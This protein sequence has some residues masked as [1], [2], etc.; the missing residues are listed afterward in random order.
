MAPLYL[1]VMEAFYAKDFA[2][3]DEL[4]F[5]AIRIVE[6]LLQ[7]GGSIKAGKSF[8][9]IAGLDLGSPRLPNVGLSDLEEEALSKKLNALNFLDDCYS[10]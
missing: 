9:R 10:G 1:K 7:F 5:R 2:E 4:Q 6:I 8:M 3:A